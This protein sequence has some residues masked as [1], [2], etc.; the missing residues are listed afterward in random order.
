MNAIQFS[1]DV[2][3]PDQHIFTPLE[4]LTAPPDFMSFVF[5]SG[6]FCYFSNNVS[7]NLKPIIF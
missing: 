5:V 7:I 4:H 2:T 1:N 3:C 6:D